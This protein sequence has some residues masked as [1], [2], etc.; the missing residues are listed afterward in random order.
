MGAGRP[1]RGMLRVMRS[2]RAKYVTNLVFI[3]HS[4]LPESTRRDLRLVDVVL[5]ALLRRRARLLR[6]DE[7]PRPKP[8]PRL[9]AEAASA[10]SDHVR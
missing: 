1:R 5:R 8:D 6:A 3:G 9:S 10:G 7:V 2:A 4:L